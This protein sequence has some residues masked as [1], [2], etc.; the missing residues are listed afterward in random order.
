MLGVRAAKSQEG[1]FLRQIPL[2]TRGT[3]LI[4]ILHK[5]PMSIQLP[6]S[7]TASK[8]AA[9]P[10]PLQSLTDQPS[11]SAPHCQWCAASPLI[12]GPSSKLS[13]SLSA[14]S[15]KTLPSSLVG[16]IRPGNNALIGEKHVGFPPPHAGARRFSSVAAAT[17]AGSA[18][19]STQPR[20]AGSRPSDRDSQPRHSARA[21]PAPSR[22]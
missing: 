19:A 7:Q 18:T 5:L 6:R 13:P 2:H 10:P 12:P 17:T 20:A 8:R 9:K 4:S 1:G 11:S 22:P 14:S 3:Y 15:V 16:L 21:A